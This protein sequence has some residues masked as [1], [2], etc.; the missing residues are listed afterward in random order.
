MQ[1]WKQQRSNKRLS[2]IADNEREH[3]RSCSLLA[4]SLSSEAHRLVHS[5]FFQWL[6]S[7][8]VCLDAVRTLIN[9]RCLIMN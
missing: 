9:T 2:S 5:R 3:H 6:I 7:I 8:A 4:R 1:P